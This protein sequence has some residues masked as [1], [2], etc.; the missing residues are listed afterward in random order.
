MLCIKVPVK[1]AQKVKKE[2]I[3][4]DLLDKEHFIKK[5]K[6]CVYFPVKKRFKT[7]Y[8]FVHKILK[9]KKPRADLK[10]SLTKKLSKDDLEFLRRSM[11]VIGDIVILEIPKELEKKEKLIANEVLRTN[12]SIKTVLKKG[13]HE[14]VFRTQKLKLL[15]GEKTKE[16]TYKENNVTLKLD[17][18]NVYFSPRLSNERKRIYK[19]VR[20]GEDMLVMFA[21]CGVY[22]LVISKN[23]KAKHITGIEINPTA[24]NY[25]LQNLLL[26]KAENVSVFLG[27]VRNIVPKLGKKYDRIV[28]PLPKQAHTF[29][30]V[31]FKASKKGTIIH[32]YQFINENEIKK[33]EKEIKEI[34]KKRKIECRIIN[35]EKCGQQAPHVFRVC[36]EFK[37]TKT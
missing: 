32:L 11:D 37:I 19:Q 9:K 35:S 28:M 33:R 23:T 27:D 16:A 17:V 25:A 21:G 8:K 34:C 12:K 15:A 5:D 26:N 29:L 2:L 13:K 31:A 3:S 10:A 14:G 18:E 24:H 4:K 6:D 7:Q 1:E 36:I 20:R 22:P 30:E